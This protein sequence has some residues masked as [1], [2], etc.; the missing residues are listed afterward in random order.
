MKRKILAL[1]A[2]VLAV[3]NAPA[4]AD[5]DVGC[6]IGTM[7]WDGH[8]GVPQKVLASTT[9][10]ILFN[11]WFG[12]TFGTLGCSP[13]TPIKSKAVVKE[14]ANANVDRLAAEM[15]SGQGEHLAAL[16]ELQGVKSEADR[17][18]YYTMLQQNFSS[19][20]SSS[21][22]TGSQVVDHV[23]ALMAKNP[24]LASYVAS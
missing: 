20:F 10:A 13:N 3:S 22:V 19:I 16:A 17:Q 6:G 12:I 5:E 21:N 7:L 23:E 9:N 15:A 14:Y 2:L 18:A 11:Q 4:F 24:Q 8:K 1:G